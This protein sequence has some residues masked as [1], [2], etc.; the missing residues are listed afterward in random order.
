MLS[1]FNILL[2]SGCVSIIALSAYGLNS[3]HAG[4]EWTPPE[5]AQQEEYVA[6]KGSALPVPPPSIEDEEIL[7][8][9]PKR[10][11]PIPEVEKPI[12]ATGQVMKKKVIH[13]DSEQITTPTAPVPSPTQ[14]PEMKADASKPKTKTISRKNVTAPSEQATA[15][16]SQAPKIETVRKVAKEEVKEI[17]TPEVKTKNIAKSESTSKPL[18]L[19]PETKVAA[20]PEPKSEKTASALLPIPGEETPADVKKDEKKDGMKIDPYPSREKQ[21]SVQGRPL[22]TKKEAINWNKDETFKVAEGFGTEIPLAL[23]LSQIVPPNYAYSF[24]EGVNPGKKITWNGGKPWNEVLSE[25][26]ATVG[27]VYE[28]DGQKLTLLKADQA[29]SKMAQKNS[30]NSGRKKKLN[31]ETND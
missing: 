17:K 13:P 3:A 1:R 16:P 24:G 30:E 11:A 25:A 5:Q 21:I 29:E 4:F 10:M 19:V 8:V 9:P 15:Q 20:P 27:L 23:A 12:K 26:I 22:P 28:I 7:T 6:P 14:P 18:P 31:Y 2:L